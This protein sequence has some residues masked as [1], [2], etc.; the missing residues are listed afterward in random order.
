MKE[1]YK[2]QLKLRTTWL[3]REETS[4]RHVMTYILF[5]SSNG[6]SHTP[7]HRQQA[8]AFFLKIKFVLRATNMAKLGCPG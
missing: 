7:S 4:C 6:S 1:S 2:L 5:I 8:L 3:N